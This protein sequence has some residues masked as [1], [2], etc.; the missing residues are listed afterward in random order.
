MLRVESHKNMESNELRN[1][2]NNTNPS[3]AINNSEYSQKLQ[4]LLRT[5]DEC[6]VYKKNISFVI[7]Q[8]NIVLNP[9]SVKAEDNIVF[10]CQQENKNER[11]L[12][13]KY[14]T[15]KSS[16]EGISTSWSSSEM[17]SES[18]AVLLNNNRPLDQALHEQENVLNKTNDPKRC[19][20]IFE[21][22]IY[23]YVI[24]QI[25]RFTPHVLSSKNTGLIQCSVFDSATK[26]TCDTV[27]YI[28]L[29]FKQYSLHK[30]IK[31]E[32]LPESPM[33]EI[34][35]PI[36][37]TIAIFSKIGLF[38]NDLHVGNIRIQSLKG[39]GPVKAYYALEEGKS[40]L[41]AVSS[42]RSE[43]HTF[44]VEYKHILCQ[45]Y[46]FD[47]STVTDIAKNILE[48]N[49]K[50]SKN[51]F[52]EHMQRRG[53][54]FTKQ[55]D[56]GLTFYDLMLPRSNSSVQYIFTLYEKLKQHQISRDN[57]V[58]QIVEDLNQILKLYDIDYTL[59][60]N[61]DF[62]NMIPELSPFAI[63]KQVKFLIL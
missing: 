18:N 54:Y 37:H 22:H 11:L 45:V 31:T 35:F 44:E 25:S 51:L 3:T 20:F 39:V 9:M 58:S 36:I 42:Q 41:L 60:L 5:Q 1:R 55:N 17:D 21:Y 13:N 62:I 4:K 50:L 34:V 61:H 6:F 46:D 27:R 63:Y 26:E 40:P 52:I 47:Y 33:K 15:K 12:A 7:F 24:P 59:L 32:L 23:K 49:N 38:H 57:Y 28:C 53:Y 8:K 30:Y 10:K 43:K 48:K 19:G 56:Q 16:L 29:P 14:L 2:N